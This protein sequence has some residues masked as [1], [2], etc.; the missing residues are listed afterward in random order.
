MSKNFKDLQKQV[1]KIIEDYDREVG[2]LELKK[3]ESDKRYK[4]YMDKIMQAEENEDAKEFSKLSA[5][6]AEEEALSKILEKKQKKL[7]ESLEAMESREMVIA[8]KKRRSEII[9]EFE[10]NAKPIVKQLMQIVGEL[11]ATLQEGDN[12]LYTWSSRISGVQK[13]DCISTEGYPRGSMADIAFGI[14]TDLRNQNI[15]L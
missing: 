7:K 1:D 2:R 6:L 8:C 5:V 3:A 4:G 14:Y 13:P 10:K 15:K 12:V 11:E 9:D